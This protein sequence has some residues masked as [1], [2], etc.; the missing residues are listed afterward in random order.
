MGSTA[1]QLDENWLPGA[2]EATAGHH[3]TPTV[4]LRSARAWKHQHPRAGLTGMENGAAAVDTSLA[5]P[6]KVR[7]GVAAGPSRPPPGAQGRIYNSSCSNRSLNTDAHGSSI[8]NGHKAESLRRPS[9]SGRWTH[10]VRPHGG[11]GSAVKR[12]EAPTPATMRRDRENTL[13][14]ER[15]QTLRPHRAGHHARGVSGRL[16]NPQ[17]QGAD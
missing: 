4:R 8:R 5:A 14:C 6:R 3:S 15:R 9:A 13:L 16:V 1:R 10:T 12:H 11:H 2:N 17:R 7:C